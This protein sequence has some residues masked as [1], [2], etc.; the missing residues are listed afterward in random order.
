MSANNGSAGA[1]HL[2]IGSAV[3][4]AS[5]LNN[6]T[7]SAFQQLLPLNLQMSELNGNEKHADLPT[8]LPTSATNPG[9]IR[10]GDIMLYGSRTLV[11]W[12]ED[13][14]SGFTYTRIG[15]VDNPEGLAAA[16]G[17]GSVDVGFAAGAGG[18]GVTATG[19][20]TSAP[21]RSTPSTSRAKRVGMSRRGP[22]TL[23]LI[24]S[25]CIAFGITY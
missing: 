16:V 7:V 14:S 9:A 13:Y 5:L 17:S 25:L 6:P 1:L 11:L 23:S 20:T 15:T 10:T 18:G 12:Y 19:A 21:P 22:K 4:T 24:V 8:A 2:T 3:F